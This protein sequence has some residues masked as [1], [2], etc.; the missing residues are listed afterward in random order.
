MCTSL[1]YR[2]ASGRAYLGRTLELTISLPYQV[3]WF[4]AGFETASR[5]EGEA[6][7]VFAARHGVL[8]VTMPAQLPAEGQKSRFQ[9][10]KIL[11]GLNSAGLTFS[12]LSYPSAGGGKHAAAMAQ[13]VLGASELGAWA[14]GQF[15]TV[16]EVK[17]ALAAQPVILQPLA[18]LGGVQSPFHYVVHDS[19]GRSLVIEFDDGEMSLY[20]NPVG[21][22]TNGPAFP[23]HLTNLGNYT[24][25]TNVD[26][27]AAKFGDYTATQPD[28]GI[29]TSG[30]PSSNTSVGRFVRAAFF[31]KYAE[32][33]QTPDAAVATLAHVM[34]N[35]DRARGISIGY[36][37][38]GGD[39]LEV[40]GLEAEKGSAYAT[41]FTSWTSLTDMDRLIF[42]VRDYSSLNYSRIDLSALKALTEPRVLPLATLS[43][44]AA[45]AT[46]RLIAAS[47]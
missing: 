35:F 41:E 46:G 3:A 33:A 14:L 2:D 23:W 12:L 43:H 15:S 47:V 16:D 26:V 34:N 30:L 25:L 39:H 17:A 45:D 40:A 1:I 8:A 5:V 22:M 27:P 13:A 10:L 19:A 18:I 29:A 21:V 20:D 4:P 24:F 11:E 38:A 9:D 6:P 36:P 42:F 44:A 37:Q 7:M 32:K 28:S 31:A